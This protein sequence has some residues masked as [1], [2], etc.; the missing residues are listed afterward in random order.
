MPFGRSSSLAG[1]TSVS[2]LL[3]MTVQTR[4]HVTFPIPF[5]S[6]TFPFL[7]H[8]IGADSRRPY[9]LAYRLFNRSSARPNYSRR[10]YSRGHAVPSVVCGKQDAQNG[11]DFDTL[12][13][14]VM[15]C[16]D[17]EVVLF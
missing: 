17:K 4:V 2:C 12:T 11:V 1:K 16:K 6:A 9:V 3:V 5:T 8:G 13:K 7:V 10:T 14:H 15:F